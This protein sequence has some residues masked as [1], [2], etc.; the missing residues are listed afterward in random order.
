MFEEEEYKKQSRILLNK[1]HVYQ[2][3]LNMM[4]KIRY[5]LYKEEWILVKIFFKHYLN[6]KTIKSINFKLEVRSNNTRE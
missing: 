6:N 2:K 5:Y 3:I 4:K 1:N